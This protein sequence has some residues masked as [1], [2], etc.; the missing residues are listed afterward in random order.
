MTL[1]QLHFLPSTRFY[2]TL[3]LLSEPSARIILF[4]KTRQGYVRKRILKLAGYFFL[5]D[6]K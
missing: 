3:A 1:T 6:E 4:N 2:S 5:R